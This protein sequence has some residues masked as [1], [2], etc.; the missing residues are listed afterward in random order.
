[1]VRSLTQLQDIAGLASEIEATLIHIQELN[2]L[3]QENNVT[4][5]WNENGEKLAKKCV[6]DCEG[7]LDKL[8]KLLIKSGAAVGS[9]NFE[10]GLTVKREDIDRRV[11]DLV[12]WPFHKPKLARAKQELLKVKL[13]ILL[14]QHTYQARLR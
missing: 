10:N 6:T 13:D 4:K 12:V 3:I 8:R 5:G 7:T 11:F 14:A 2:R 1:M 9:A